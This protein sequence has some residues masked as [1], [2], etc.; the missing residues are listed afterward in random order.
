[1]SLRLGVDGG[2]MGLLGSVRLAGYLGYR[3]HVSVGGTRW[4]EPRVLIC[5]GSA[6]PLERLI[7]AV[8]RIKGTIKGT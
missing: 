7:S 2:G 3:L 1:M 5:R 4:R 6:M 8:L